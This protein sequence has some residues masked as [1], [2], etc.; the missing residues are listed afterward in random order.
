MARLILQFEDRREEF[1]LTEP[2]VTLGRTDDNQVPVPDIKASR[3]HCEIVQTD[4]GYRLVELNSRNGTQ[5]NGEY[6]IEQNLKNGDEIRI[7]KAVMTFDEERK[8][9]NGNEDAEET[10]RAFVVFEGPGYPK[11][12][13][14]LDDD[15]TTIGRHKSNRVQIENSSLSNRHG[16]FILTKDALSY[17]DF[18]STNGTLVDGE[19]FEE[20]TIE[21]NSTI[22]IGEMTIEFH[23]TL[24][25][26]TIFADHEEK[27]P[28]SIPYLP[29][30]F[31]NWKVL[32]AAAA[33]LVLFV[34]AGV[35]IFSGDSDE[36]QVKRISIPNGDFEE[37][38]SNGRQPR[39]WSFQPKSYYQ[40]LLDSDA[41]AKG[42][43]L[44][45]QQSDK[46]PL[47]VDTAV[48]SDEMFRPAPDAVVV[49]GRVRRQYP[50]GFAGFRITWLSDNDPTL[51]SSTYL[52]AGKGKA[53]RP[54]TVKAIAPPWADAYQ[55]AC[56]SVGTRAKTWFDEV[57]VETAKEP[58]RPVTVAL[59]P[60]WKL[61]L[62]RHG[63]IT[64]INESGAVLFWD[65]EF[66]FGR[67]NSNTTTSQRFLR[68][69]APP[70][71]GEKSYE[72]EGVIPEF[73]SSRKI[74]FALKITV[75]DNRIEIACTMDGEGLKKFEWL[76][77]RLNASSSFLREL[78]PIHL[79]NE[80]AFIKQKVPFNSVA[81][82]ALIW[83]VGDSQWAFEVNA[84][85]A[86]RCAEN[87][88]RQEF[89]FRTP[90]Q[91]P[92]EFKLQVHYKPRTMIADLE[93]LVADVEQAEILGR[94]SS[95]FRLY[96]EIRNR[97]PYHPDYQAAAHKGTKKLQSYSK[98]MKEEALAAIKQAEES[99]APLD[100]KYAGQSMEAF[101]EWVA[102]DDL[103]K[104]KKEND[105]L[106]GMLEEIA[107]KEEDQAAQ[108]LY[109]Q[110]LTLREDGK[111]LLAREC[112]KYVVEHYP[113]TSWGE[114][115]KSAIGDLLDGEKN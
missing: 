99:K 71:R 69:P 19:F 107:R 22:K 76:E 38:M 37:A 59:D 39:A 46:A 81:D 15:T 20:G 101:L 89:A 97:A 83:G 52:S 42:N 43:A 115:S 82:Q 78:S 73:E 87:A 109:D 34:I 36:R 3:R 68:L 1:P 64:A 28:I 65:A 102:E 48:V 49:K 24:R 67:E 53:W 58:A 111:P 106:N 103:P 88:G 94:Y 13:F 8:G 63:R 108:K 9:D 112:F 100:I 86:V 11:H 17:Q 60:Q 29:P 14:E 18:G 70:G 2:V 40:V 47:G 105:L 90:I 85:T 21:E 50:G 32:G 62:D 4:K 79:L 74:Q 6:I 91:S 66:V 98:Q 57:S 44:L 77:W 30:A 113:K 96:E 56:S 84:S 110:A 104:Y 27:G 61:L 41:S 33:V 12:F 92:L 10:P 31:Q 93:K 7:G 114:K 26:E 16:Q 72:L 25:P 23:Q 95:A 75:V 55:L 80:T 45:I 5:I 54:V 35:M 51:K